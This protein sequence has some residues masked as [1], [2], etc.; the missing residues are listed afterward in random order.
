MRI[1]VEV[2]LPEV[3]LAPT[4]RTFSL[5]TDVTK[6]DRF[7]HLGVWIPNA[8][9]RCATVGTRWMLTGTT[10]FVQFTFG[11][12]VEIFLS[13]RL[14]APKAITFTLAHRTQHFRSWRNMCLQSI[15]AE[16]LPTD[17][18]ETQLTQ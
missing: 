12:F 6:R 18:L 16:Y 11:I 10:H 2:Y 15:L 3:L 5:F 13:E 17:T 1:F 14:L 9:S 7:F 4:A 8:L